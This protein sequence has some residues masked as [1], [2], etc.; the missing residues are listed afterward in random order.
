MPYIQHNP[1]FQ[2]KHNGYRGHA[3]F[4]PQSGAVGAAGGG[5]DFTPT[6]YLW[7]MIGGV[8]FS[9]FMVW[10]TIRIFTETD[11]NAEQPTEE[12]VVE[13]Q[14]ETKVLAQREGAADDDS[15]STTDLLNTWLQGQLQ[16][17]IEELDDSLRSLDDQLEN[18]RDSLELQDNELETL[19]LQFGNG[20]NTGNGVTNDDITNAELLMALGYEEV[21]LRPKPDPQD[22]RYNEPNHYELVV[23][24]NGVKSFL[25]LDTGA[26][27]T[28]LDSNKKEAMSVSI[29]GEATANGIGGSQ[30]AE[31]G[32]ILLTILD[33]DGEDSILSLTDFQVILLD[34]DDVN[35]NITS[36]GDCTAPYYHFCRIDGLVG[37]D[38]LA[39]T[40]AIIDYESHKIYLKI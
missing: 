19:R 12:A 27:S 39:A 34:L 23:E 22:S 29:T 16:N 5:G 24:V 4:H 13:D 6:Q 10:G 35:A 14:E 28:V 11:T 26:S 7:R 31:V 33:S 1:R 37:H 38:F 25:L 21:D 30:A 9:A 36:G 2:Q 40:N 15:D 20:Q 8:V 18:I 3:P 32:E 17:D